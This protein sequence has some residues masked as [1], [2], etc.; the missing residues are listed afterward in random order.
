MRTTVRG[1][2]DR[3]SQQLVGQP[4]G[5]A[6]I[7]V[8]VV[9]E[10]EVF[11]LG[12]RACLS[13]HPLVEV[14]AQVDE[15]IDMDVVVVS[16]QVARDRRFTCPLI[17]CGELPSQL[18]QGNLA[19]AALPRGTLTAEQI[20]ASVHAAAAGLRVS[21]PAETVVACPLGTRPREV[22]A[23][24]AAGAATREIAQRLGYSE[25]TIKNSIREVLVA[26][27]VSSRT[28]AVAEGIRLGLI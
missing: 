6:T 22:L 25:R 23:L 18:A 2:N 9:D 20:V 26:L 7:R 24:L 14:L 19:L 21:A 1:V 5:S 10:H 3:A 28:Q 17:V 8:G 16:P 13:A 27:H 12:V 15:S 11:A 4:S